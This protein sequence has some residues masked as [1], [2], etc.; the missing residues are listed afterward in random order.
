MKTTYK[1]DNLTIN[2]SG[3]FTG[4]NIIKMEGNIME[5]Y[6]DTTGIKLTPSPNGEKCE[7]NGTGKTECCCDECDHYLICFPQ[8][9]KNE[10]KAK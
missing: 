2:T 10:G 6:I 8:K 4:D 3:D 9:G 1:D 7:G 5:G